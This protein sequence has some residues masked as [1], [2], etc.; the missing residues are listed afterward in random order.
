MSSKPAG[1]L[2][3]ILAFLLDNA[4]GWLLFMPIFWALG[5][6]KTIPEFTYYLFVL[7]LWSLG[8]HVIIASLY[9][10][11]SVSYF[12][13]TAGKLLTGIHIVDNQGRPLSTKRA[14]FRYFIGYP[15]STVM[16][17]L[18][19]LSIRRDAEKRGWHDKISGSYV[20]T[21]NPSQWLVALLLVI[22]L[23]I[24]E[25]FFFGQQL[26][27]FTTGPV[28]KQIN[29]QMKQTEQA[30]KIAS[31]NPENN[32]S[33]AFYEQILT[34][35]KLADDNKK[36]E[37]LKKA[38]DLRA[39]AVTNEEK[40]VT[41]NLLGV[42]IDYTDD[43]STEMHFKNA[44]KFYPDFIQA[45]ANL[46]LTQSH[47]KKGDEALKNAQKAV[48][49]FPKDAFFRYTLSTAYFVK[50]DMKNATKEIETAVSLDPKNEFYKGYLTRLQ[51]AYPQPTQP[52]KSIQKANSSS[53]K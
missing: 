18:G 11:L 2:R 41:E 47:Q 51:E 12:Y 33:K 28:M 20:V 31:Y 38:R 34:I 46:S 3:R 1:L 13:G 24:G 35:K 19:Y 5:N 29:Q 44:I 45:Y 8:F 26:I 25:L 16:F 17:G 7:L 21:K 22:I 50:S 10:V 42:V 27:K 36:Q 15:F 4:I 32:V 52:M 6:S 40:A 49:V 14:L 30:N 39:R 37:A 23:T 9:D 53:K 43:A 48:K